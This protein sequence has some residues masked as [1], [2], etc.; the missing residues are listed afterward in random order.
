MI[1][2]PSHYMVPINYS[3]VHISQA[4]RIFHA[5][6]GGGGKERIIRLVDQKKN[7]SGRSDWPGFCELRQNLGGANQIIDLLDYVRTQ[8]WKQVTCAHNDNT[9]NPCRLHKAV[10]ITK[11]IHSLPSAVDVYIIID[12]YTRLRTQDWKQVTCAHNDNIILTIRTV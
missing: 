11:H 1:T 5:R 7:T 2:Y 9:D 6:K 8:D 3:Q 12:I 4:S 10:Q